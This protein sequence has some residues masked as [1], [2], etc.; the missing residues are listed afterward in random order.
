MKHS[1]PLQ[2]L[3]DIWTKYLANELDDE[4]RRWYGSDERG[5]VYSTRRPEDVVIYSGR[6]GRELLTL[7][8]CRQAWEIV[9]GE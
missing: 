5:R 4:A 1:H 2:R 3:A 6:G 7:E 8:D 9:N